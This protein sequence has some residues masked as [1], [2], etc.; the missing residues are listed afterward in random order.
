MASNVFLDPD[1]SLTIGERADCCLTKWNANVFTNALGQFAVG[2]TAEN[3]QF[4]L[5]RKHEGVNLGVRKSRWQSSKL[6]NRHF[7]RE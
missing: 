5:K 3:F 6:A 7:F 4:W 1:V 2:R